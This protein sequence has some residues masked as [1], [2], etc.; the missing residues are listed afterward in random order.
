[1]GP[2]LWLSQ[3]QP[4]VTLAPAVTAARSSSET[5]A[6]ITR[7]SH[8]LL[9][10]VSEHSTLLGNDPKAL[11]LIIAFQSFSWDTRERN[12]IITSETGTQ[13]C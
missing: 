1:M 8:I 3:L 9:F 4:Y 12:H 10:S 6:T 2:G 7:D 5:G 11:R 13:K